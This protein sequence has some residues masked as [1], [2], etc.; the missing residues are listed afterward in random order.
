MLNFVINL[1]ISA[2]IAAQSVSWVAI[3]AEAAKIPFIPEVPFYSQFSDIHSEKWQKLGC[4]ITSLAMLVELY[5]PGSV[6][7][8][9]LLKEGINA[10]AFIDGAGWS[11]NGLISLAGKYGLSG[12]SY[13]FSHLGAEDALVQLE[14][15]LNEGP[16]MVSIHYKFE[17]ENPIPHLVVI[18]G[19]SDGIVYYNDPA[20]GEG[21]ISI[22]RFTEAWKKRFIAIWPADKIAPTI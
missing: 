5:R 14:K 19:I 3:P 11:H 6:S 10:G 18:K 1:L 8:D 15:A 21:N 13:N 7:V 17:P 16:V 12:K 2:S 20:S 9:T 22:K 4:G